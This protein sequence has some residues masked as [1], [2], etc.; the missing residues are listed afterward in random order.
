MD[1][2][3]PTFN[4]VTS[5]GAVSSTLYINRYFQL[6]YCVITDEEK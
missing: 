4:H 3:Q 1:L 6:S 5:F 2:N